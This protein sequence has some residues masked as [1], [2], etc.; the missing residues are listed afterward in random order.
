VSILIVATTFDVGDV[1]FVWPN[2]WQAGL[3][4][5]IGLISFCAHGLVV[6]AFQRGSAS[7]LAPLQYLEI[8]SATLFGFLVF[9]DFPD[10]LT[11]V[12]IGLIVGSG[13]YI[14]H[15]ERVRKQAAG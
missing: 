1:V 9:A 4:A 3:L 8:V 15:R 6:A 11:W 10:L 14:T 5:L 13:L 7:L 2:A 12:G